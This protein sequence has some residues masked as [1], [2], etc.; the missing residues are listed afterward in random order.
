MFTI[1]SICWCAL[2][3]LVYLWIVCKIFIWRF[4]CTIKNDKRITHLVTFCTA[5]FVSNYRL[6][7]LKID[8]YTCVGDQQENETKSRRLPYPTEYVLSDL[9]LAVFKLKSNVPLHPHFTNSLL[10]EKE[11]RGKQMNR[12]WCKSTYP[13]FCITISIST[14]VDFLK[15]SDR[16][17]SKS[18]SKKSIWLEIVCKKIDDRLINFLIWNLWWL[19]NSS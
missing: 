7:W 4:G 17:W 11:V 12:K 6:W 5:L 15:F 14:A 16:N 1:S 19:R 9:M 18:D 10:S 13:S 8:Y 3:R 2:Y